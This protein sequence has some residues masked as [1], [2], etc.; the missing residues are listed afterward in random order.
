MAKQ[1]SN[2]WG[3]GGE[4]QEDSGAVQLRRQ[5]FARLRSEISES[6]HTLKESYQEG[7]TR[8][9]VGL[10]YVFKDLLAQVKVALQ[11]AWGRAIWAVFWIWIVWLCWR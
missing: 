3:S 8:Q 6:F 7:K 1:G 2:R 10:W 4:A 5:P 9:G 11:S